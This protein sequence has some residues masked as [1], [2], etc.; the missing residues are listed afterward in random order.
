MASLDRSVTAHI[1]VRG[2]RFEIIVDPN[3]A[4]DF[5]LGKK[6]DFNNILVVEEIFK[7]AN[8][9]ER[10]KGESL[11]KAFGTED[12]FEIAKKIVLDGE[13]PI[14]TEQ[15]RQM[16]EEKRKK[17]ITI[18]SRES[19]DPRTHAP[20]PPQRIERAMEEARVKIDPFKSATEQLDEIVSALRPIIPLKFEKAR[21]AVRVP[22]DIAQKSYGML[23]EYHIQ[24]EEWANDGS[25]IVV[26]EIP[27]GTQPEFFDR[28]NHLT[29]GRAQIKDVN[30]K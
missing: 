6:T 24:Q 1:D 29:A 11:K 3:L 14:T 17:I 2:E 13:V 28:I 5:K 25:L 18:I 30:R 27:A 10:H 8:K 26:I 4:L 20:H 21:L 15:R 16:T 9:G 19:I 22:A 7:D 23:K 12:I